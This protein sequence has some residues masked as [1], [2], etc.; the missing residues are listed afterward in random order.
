MIMHNITF[1]LTIALLLLIGFFF[2]SIR[3]HTMCALVTE[4]QTCALPIGQPVPEHAAARGLRGRCRLR[5]RGPAPWLSAGTWRRG[6][7]GPLRRDHF[8]ASLLRPTVSPR[9]GAGS[10]SRPVPSLPLTAPLAWTA[11]LR[12]PPEPHPR[13]PPC[14]PFPP[15]APPPI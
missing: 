10:K 9:P 3:R 12:H 14:P 15:G 11:P 13:P 1:N 2:S 8:G 5:R 7:A 4:V 6:A